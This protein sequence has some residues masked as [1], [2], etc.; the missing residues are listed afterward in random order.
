MNKNGEGSTIELLV[1][2]ET[3]IKRSKSETLALKALKFLQK[4]VQSVQNAPKSVYE[5]K[6]D[7][8]H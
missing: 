6:T 1:M 7:K 4:S 5:P 8:T 3:M 2:H